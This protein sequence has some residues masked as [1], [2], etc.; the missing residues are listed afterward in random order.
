MLDTFSTVHRQATTSSSKPIQVAYDAAER[1][2][3]VADA[4]KSTPICCMLNDAVSS[5]QLLHDCDELIGIEWLDN[6]SHR[7]RLAARV[8]LFGL[9]LGC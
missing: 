3:L 8:F 9:R 2:F 7:A 6:P 5:H 4:D 1:P